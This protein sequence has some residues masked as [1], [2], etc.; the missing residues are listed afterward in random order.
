MKKVLVDYEQLLREFDSCS[1]DLFGAQG[2][3]LVKNN[4]I[5]KI[6]FEP[7][8]LKYD[9]TN[10]ESKKISFPIKYLYDNTEM[11][12]KVVGE[13]M[14]YFPKKSITWSLNERVFIDNL[15]KKYTE[16]IN[17]IKKFYELN[18][19]DLST[20][21]ILYDEFTGFSL[22]DTTS[23]VVDQNNNYFQLNKRRIDKSLSYVIVDDLIDISINDIANS[24]LFRN[25][26][27]YGK[28]G[29]ELYKI[30][31]SMFN[32]NEFLFI[33]LLEIYCDIFKNGDLGPVKTIEDMKNYTK[34]LKKG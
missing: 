23:W 29:V 4:I 26:A 11:Q 12:D 34:M 8:D 22:I 2:F 13:L 20:P 6:Y 9:I 1:I 14:E 3:C 19:I 15:I 33:E 32:D 17:E 31:M 25:L 24:H 28:Q 21:N 7:R 30:L 5:E 10:Y 27:K 16:I 18:M